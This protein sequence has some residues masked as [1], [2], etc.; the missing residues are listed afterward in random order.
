MKKV[1]HSLSIIFFMLSLF[2]TYQALKIPVKPA[3]SRNIGLHPIQD[4]SLP[5]PEEI[6][7]QPP[8]P[9]QKEPLPEQEAVAITFLNPE[10]VSAE[11]TE[12]AAPVVAASENETLIGKSNSL[13]SVAE[14]ETATEKTDS[15]PPVAQNETKSG[16]ADSHP[17]V[18]G[19]RFKM[20]ERVLAV[21]G[22]KVFR[23]GQT[24]IQ[25]NLKIAV[26]KMIPEI[27]MNSD[28]Q[29]IVEGHTSSFR[30]SSPD[31]SGYL[32][33]KELSVYR[34]QAIADMLI[35]R[36]IPA[37]RI[38]VFGYGNDRP[39]ASD[40]TYEGRVKNRRVEVKLIT[41]SKV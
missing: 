21:I 34:A 8:E 36:G 24:I 6:P 23:A 22:T 26:D 9:T 35:E 38:S 32:N 40:D 41:W 1:I 39:V 27:S 18:E 31:G 25:E 3:I 19:D 29:L 37:D 5:G 15:S 17:P 12:P 30:A 33:N 14:N 20:V 10:P 7:Q 11:P 4:K 2:I 16:K 28:Y 13:P